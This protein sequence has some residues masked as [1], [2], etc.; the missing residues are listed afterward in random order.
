MEL[1]L[2][3][4]SEGLDGTRYTCKAVTVTGE[5]HNQTVAIQ[6]KGVI[7]SY[8]Y[9]LLLMSDHCHDCYVPIK[10]LALPVAY[11]T[12]YTFL[13]VSQSERFFRRL[14]RRNCLY[15]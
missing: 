12:I 11:W 15:S 14:N 3:P 6:V 7:A 4:N 8:L 2:T 5:V 9:H 13:E 1:V 10:H